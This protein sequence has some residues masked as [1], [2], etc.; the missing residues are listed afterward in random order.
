[1]FLSRLKTTSPITI[2]FY[3]LFA[4]LFCFFPVFHHP[5]DDLYSH[6]FFSSTT[7]LLLGVL[8]PVLQS[9]GLNNLIYEKDVIKKSSLVVAPVFLLLCTPFLAEA[10][11]WIV[12]FLLIFY[13][14]I[15]FGCFQ[16]DKPFSLAF[17]ANFLL[18]TISLFHPDVILLFPLIIVAFLTFSNLTWRSFVISIIGLALPILL[19]WIH[20]FLFD[21]PFNY[22]L[23]SY[24]LPSLD[25]AIFSELAYTKL[26]WCIV[27]AIIIILSFV[28]LFFWMYK[29]SI[30]SRK[31]FFITL[32]Y[33]L[34]LVFI[35]FENNYFL[36]LTPIT[37]IVANFFVY[38]K[39]TRLTEILFFLFVI[40]SFYY[41]LSI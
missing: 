9:V 17:N 30:R 11:G 4:V 5:I 25:L 26:V 28:E 21:F 29:K 36:S 24:R 19:Y 23:P 13:L 33:L 2:V 31:S 8:L 32:A 12:S 1:M 6:T 27:V 34:L 10:N 41:R 14:N 20:T 16:K 18:S 39:R 38:S 40:T 15:I 22:G 35:N 7:I 37:I 3:M